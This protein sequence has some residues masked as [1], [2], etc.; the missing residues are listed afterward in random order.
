MTANL[1]NRI[2]RA[3][4]ERELDLALAASFPAS[5]PLPWTLGVAVEIEE[6]RRAFSPLSGDDHRNADV[7]AGHDPLAS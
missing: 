2:S 1:M 4:Y 5:D 7:E 3:Q 6:V